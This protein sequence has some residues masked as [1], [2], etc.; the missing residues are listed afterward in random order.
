MTGNTSWCFIVNV[1]LSTL[2]CFFENK[3]TSDQWICHILWLCMMLLSPTLH[4]AYSIFFW[5]LLKFWHHIRVFVTKPLSVNTLKK[6]RK[7]EKQPSVFSRRRPEFSSQFSEQCNFYGRLKHNHISLY[8]LFYFP[9]FIVVL[10]RKAIMAS[11]STT[12]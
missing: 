1:L 4:F 7:F 5:V 10:H 11:I 2:N 8:F 6:L 12:F 3:E 9:S